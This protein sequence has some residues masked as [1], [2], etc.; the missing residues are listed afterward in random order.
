MVYTN[1]N[2]VN[3]GCAPLPP[4]ASPV[5]LAPLDLGLNLV[6]CRVHHLQPPCGEVPS[7]SSD[8]VQGS[9]AHTTCKDWVGVIL[10]SASPSGSI[11]ITEKGKLF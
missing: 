8:C 7:P 9:A 4:R 10:V 2:K 3:D 5:P 11:C 6:M 1:S